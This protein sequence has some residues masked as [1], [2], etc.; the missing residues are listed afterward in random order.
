MD[1]TKIE[2]GFLALQHS[3]ALSYSDVQ[4]MT[5]C[6]IRVNIVPM[7]GGGQRVWEADAWNISFAP[8]LKKQLT[9][10]SFLSNNEAP[11]INTSN[12]KYTSTA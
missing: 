9:V 4:K 10:D 11:I 1:L 2:P 8:K 5:D 6:S 7:L 12:E 3:R